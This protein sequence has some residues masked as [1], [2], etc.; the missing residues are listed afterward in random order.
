MASELNKIVGKC[1]SLM[2]T[3]DNLINNISIE[4][5]NET[6]DKLHNELSLKQR[7]TDK[8]VK[9]THFAFE[10]EIGYKKSI[11]VYFLRKDNL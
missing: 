5:C 2:K 11:V 8:S 7:N 6:Y 9:K 10:R 4:L 3:S 1:F